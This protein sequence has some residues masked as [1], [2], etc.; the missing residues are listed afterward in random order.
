MATSGQSANAMH[1]CCQTDFGWTIWC[2]AALWFQQNW[3]IMFTF[4]DRVIPSTS[5]ERSLVIKAILSPRALAALCCRKKL[6]MYGRKYL[7]HCKALSCIGYNQVMVINFCFT[8]RSVSGLYMA[9]VSL[10]AII[11]KLS[12]R[13]GRVGEKAVVSNQISCLY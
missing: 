2:C 1:E 6:C 3:C 8:F 12:K 10:S 5:S 9:I 4:A 7:K 13:R 11:V